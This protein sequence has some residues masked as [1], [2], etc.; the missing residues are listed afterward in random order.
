MKFFN[1]QKKSLKKFWIILTEL[2]KKKVNFFSIFQ[3]HGAS[4][5]CLKSCLF[6]RVHNSTIYPCIDDKISDLFIKKNPPQTPLE[7]QEIAF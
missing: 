6:T 5:M 3:K 4:R 1:R 2:K 7:R